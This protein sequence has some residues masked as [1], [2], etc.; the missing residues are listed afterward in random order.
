M[1]RQH[2]LGIED[3]FTALNPAVE[4]SRHPAQGRMADPFLNVGDHLP[5]VGLVPAPVQLLGRQTK[6]D[7]QIAR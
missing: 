3:G 1:T 7:N 5:G 2:E 6:L 4:C